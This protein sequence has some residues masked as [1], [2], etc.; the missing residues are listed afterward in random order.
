MSVQVP[1]GYKQT[2]VGVIPEDWAVTS[3]EELVK[4]EILDKPMDGNHGELHPKKS[5]FVNFGI[6]FIM[7]NDVVNGKIDFNKCVFITDSQAR[8]LRKG[9]NIV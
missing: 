6:P 5:D 7:A 3:V 2:E 1:K 9:F 4:F 8:K